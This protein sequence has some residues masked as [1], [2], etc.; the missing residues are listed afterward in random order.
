MELTLDVI[1]R[2]NSA[3]VE[4]SSQTQMCFRRRQSPA[5]S[6]YGPGHVTVRQ[7]RFF[8][9]YTAQASV[10]EGYVYSSFVSHIQ[11][12]SSDN[13]SVSRLKPPVVKEIKESDRNVS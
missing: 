7:L 13:V 4:A 11:I 1:F 2:E 6:L 9:C 10:S 5:S 8:T 12:V 3:P